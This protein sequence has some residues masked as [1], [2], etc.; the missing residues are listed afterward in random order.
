MKLFILWYNS[1]SHKRTRYWDGGFEAAKAPITVGKDE[2]G[3]EIKGLMVYPKPTWSYE[4]FEAH[5]GELAQIQDAENK[6]KFAGYTGL[7]IEP[8]DEFKVPIPPIMEVVH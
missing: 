2:E 1:A 6:A 4:K 3:T 5:A 8:I 7:V